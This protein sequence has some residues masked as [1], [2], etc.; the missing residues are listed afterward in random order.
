MLVGTRGQAPTPHFE[1]REIASKLK[2][3]MLLRVVVV[4]FLLGATI[5]LSDDVPGAHQGSTPAEILVI[6][7]GSG[8][9]VVTLLGTLAARVVRTQR[10]LRAVAYL[11]LAFDTVFAAGLV[12]FTGGTSSSFSFFFSLAIAAA[13]IV[14]YRPGALFSATCSGVFF[15]V[16]GLMETGTLPSPDWLQRMLSLSDGLHRAST[17]AATDRVAML[18]GMAYSLINNI[19]AF[20]AIGFLASHLSERL[21]RTD[22]QLRANQDSLE[23]LQAL[24]AAIVTSIPSG[25]VTINPA[26]QVTWFS[27]TA[28]AITGIEGRRVLLSGVAGVLP[29]VG[30]MLAEAGGSARTVER[31]V[32]AQLPHGARSLHTT[33]AP[34]GRNAGERLGSILILEDVTEVRQLEVRMA[35]EKRFGEIGRLAASIAHDIRNPLT[36]ISGSIQLL[37]KAS[38][39]SAQE[40]RLMDIVSRETDALNAWIADFLTYARPRKGDLVAL[41]LAQSVSEA[42]EVLKH[43]EKSVKITVDVALDPCAMIRA[44]PPA[45]KQVIWNILTNAVQAMP[46]GGRL[47]VH[48]STDGP[49]RV[50]RIGDTGPGIP[51][52]TRAR[53]FEPFFTTK[54]HGTGLGLATVYRSVTDHGGSVDIQSEVGHGA[55]VIIRLPALVGA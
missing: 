30:E 33:L 34:L 3:L 19:L 6:A 12:S 42:L 40:R 44:D 23:D 25:L 18:G 26:N 45:I 32:E 27:P 17:M 24:Q 39:L 16:I 50:M 14:M 7:L 35:R 48:V 11:Q 29:F 37:A 52:E 21:R 15:V 54:E 10:Q 43:D 47:T 51:P 4:G 53:L 13:A 5:L 36:A 22:Q 2:W 55:E 31:T 28:E 20:Y 1:T 8:V 38:D 46:D 41:D 49:W 9:L